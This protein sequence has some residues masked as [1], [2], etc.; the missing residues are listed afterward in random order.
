M[1]DWIPKDASIAIALGNHYLY[2]NSGIHD[3]RIIKGQIVEQGSIAD[4]VINK[5]TRIEKLMDDSLFGIAYY[6]IGYPITVNQQ[7]AALVIIL[8]T[9]YYFLTREPLSFLTGKQEDTWNPIKIEE[10]AYIESLH[11]KTWFYANNEAYSLIQTLKNLE[12]LLPHCFLRIH[13]SY[14]VNISYI[15]EISRDFTSNLQITLID[16]TV[17]S[18]SQTYVNSFRTKLGF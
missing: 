16:G 4:S 5:G 1:K 18:V 12:V 2:Y 15:K 17:L 9:N 7:Q 10:V 13:R 14:I 6:G 11:K 3:I 8:P